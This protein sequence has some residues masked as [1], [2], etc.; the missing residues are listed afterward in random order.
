MDPADE[1]REVPSQGSSSDMPLPQS[2]LDGLLVVD[3]SRHLPGPLV[4]RILG[5]LGARILKIEEPSLGDSNRQ[6]PP[7]RDGVSSLSALLLAGH[8]SL[9]LDLGKEQAREVLLGLLGGADVMV[10]SFRPGTLANWGLAPQELRQRFPQ[11]VVCSLS[12]WGQDGPEAKRAGHDLSYQAVAGSLASNLSVPAVQVAD[13][14]G[15]W[16]GAAAVLAA[17]FRRTQSGCGCWI[18]QALLDAAGHANLTAW[19]EEADGPKPIGRPLKL[20]GALPC[21]GLYLTRDGGYLALG[22]LEPKFWRQFCGAVGRRDL[23]LLQYSDN[24]ETKRKVAELVAGRSRAEW[25]E[26]LSQHDLPVAPVLSAAEAREH[27]QVK[28]RGLLRVAADGLPRLGYPALFDGERP[29]SA[30]AYPALGEHTA[31]LAEEFGFAQ[32]LSRLA[33]KRGGIGRRLSIKRGLLA[34]AGRLRRKKS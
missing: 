7:L 9:A 32:G 14:I 12:G 23:L 30:E 1:K 21:Y 17:L 34:L 27:P 19:A 18:D 31:A 6:L 20:S 26:L 3:L 28:A 33:K 16:S 8:E 22:A 24:P 13:Q 10:E 11:L 29:R 5:D 2:P 4:T 25:T 15:G